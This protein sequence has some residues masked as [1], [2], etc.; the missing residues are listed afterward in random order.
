M[1]ADT[2]TLNTYEEMSDYLQQQSEENLPH[3]THRHQ[4][5][6]IGKQTLKILGSFSLRVNQFAICIKGNKNLYQNDYCYVG[7]V[8]CSQT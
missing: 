3:R 5:P 4:L 7:F 8:W 6:S 1:S 2:E